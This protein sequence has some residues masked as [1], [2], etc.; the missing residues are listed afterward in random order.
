MVTE[1]IFDEKIRNWVFI[2]LLYV[3]F[4]MGIIRM[5][6]NKL[7]SGNKNAPM[8]ILEE[9]KLKENTEK[10]M[11]MKAKKLRALCG[12]IPLESFGSRKNFLSAPGRGILSKVEAKEVDPMAA[13]QGGGM[14]NPE[15]MTGMLKNNLFMAIVTPLQ[16]GVIS[17]F[18]S[19]FLVGKVPFPLT[20]RFRELLQ[21]G[22]S[23]SSLDVQYISSISLYFLT[24]FGFSS[25]YRIILSEN[26]DELGS[27][28]AAMNPMMAMGPQPS[29]GGPESNKSLCDKEINNLKV[30]KHKFAYEDCD[31]AL[32]KKFKASK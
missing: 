2:P 32:I 16:Y 15:M 6:I 12:L 28:M 7:M 23:V 29:L 17:T 30:V 19:G 24:M 9:D 10:M 18:F 26:D 1:L 13:L 20:Q 3:M 11:I 27:Q 21:S 8:K 5:S 14:M 31:K 25:L 4:I 22:I